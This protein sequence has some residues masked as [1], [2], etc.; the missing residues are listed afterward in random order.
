MP[1]LLR[2]VLCALLDGHAEEGLLLSLDRLLFLRAL[3][4]LLL[5]GSGFPIQTRASFRQ[6]E[7]CVV[8]RVEVRMMEMMQVDQFQSHGRCLEVQCCCGIVRGETD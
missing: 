7:C 2:C 1:T 3:L 8:S 4:L 6:V 5:L